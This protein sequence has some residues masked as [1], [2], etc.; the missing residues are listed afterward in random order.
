MYKV[1]TRHNGI[2]DVELFDNFDDAEF[3][4]AVRYLEWRRLGIFRERENDPE[5]IIEELKHH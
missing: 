1:Y 4:Q 3:E 5:C 2:H